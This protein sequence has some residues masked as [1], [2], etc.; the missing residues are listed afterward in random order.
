M[1]NILRFQEETA[2][3]G[4]IKSINRCLCF[5]ANW[6]E[7][8]MTDAI[9]PLPAWWESESWRRFMASRSQS[10]CGRILVSRVFIKSATCYFQ[11]LSDFELPSRGPQASQTVLLP[12][13]LSSDNMP[14]CWRYGERR[15]HSLITGANHLLYKL[16]TR[17]ALPFIGQGGGG[18]R[19]VSGWLVALM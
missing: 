19:A 18:S 6:T 15:I 13:H 16:F 5:T 3:K 10:G 9:P 8:S 2:T 11:S 7:E 1:C 17:W 12:L 4:Q 14:Q